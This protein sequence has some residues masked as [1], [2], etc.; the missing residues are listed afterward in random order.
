MIGE[1]INANTT[2]SSFSTHLF[3]STSN[4]SNNDYIKSQ[5]K[6]LQLYN[7][8]L[9]KIDAS[10]EDSRQQI[11]KHMKLTRSLEKAKKQTMAIEQGL[12]LRI[13]K[14]LGIYT[15]KYEKYLKMIDDM[16]KE[17]EEG[18]EGMMK[19]KMD[20]HLDDRVI[21]LIEQSCYDRIMK[22]YQYM[23]DLRKSFPNGIGGVIYKAYKSYEDKDLDLIYAFVV[24][25]SDKGSDIL[26]EALF[27]SIDD[28]SD[29]SISHYDFNTLYHRFIQQNTYHNVHDSSHSYQVSVQ[30]LSGEQA[31][32]RHSD[33]S[34]SLTTKI[35]WNKMIS[36]LQKRFLLISLT[37]A[38]LLFLHNQ[39]QETFHFDTTK[40][41]SALSS[42]SLSTFSAIPLSSM[43][44]L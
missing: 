9:K 28:I 3:N 42:S 40:S 4:S 24:E 14:S 25:E 17:Q 33:S 13:A 36:M 20:F 5:S 22:E 35:P 21:Y 41:T 16:K 7:V 29:Q 31:S 44:L 32:D 26:I 15:G 10:I 34:Q 8:K 2:T 39:P 38:V 19:K 27:Q 1:S 37:K 30:Q 23:K 18:E 12:Q 43:T 11:A 6:T